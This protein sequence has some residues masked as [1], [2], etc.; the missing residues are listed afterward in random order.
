MDIQLLELDVACFDL[1]DEFYK[2]LGSKP[3]GLVF[4]AGIM[5]SRIDYDNNWNKIIKTMNTNYVGVLGML[6][7]IAAYFEKNED[8]SIIEIYPVASDRGRRSNYIIIYGSAKAAFTLYLS[9]L[10]S[11]LLKSNVYV[12]AVKSGFTK[13]KETEY[14]AFPNFLSAQQQ[15]IAEIVYKAQQ[16][17]EESYMSDIRQKSIMSIIKLIFERT[18]L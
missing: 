15:R 10:R 13:I 5:F 16:S 6:N 18:I 12:M 4:V 9:G 1:N 11:R 3:V 8:G 7:I 17:E 14:I 2:T